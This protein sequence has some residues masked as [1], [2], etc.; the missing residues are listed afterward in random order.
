MVQYIE[1]HN[2]YDEDGAASTSSGDGKGKE[3]LRAG[4]SQGVAS[5]TEAS[6]SRNERGILD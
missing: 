4:E 3:G 6:S 5:A 1:A 2:L